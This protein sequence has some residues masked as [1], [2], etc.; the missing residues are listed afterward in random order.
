MQP[1]GSRCPVAL[2]VF[3]VIRQGGTAVVE[4]AQAA[5]E[6]DA[7]PQN[8]G[9]PGLQGG[10]EGQVICADSVRPAEGT[11]V[12][13]RRIESGIALGHSVIQIVIVEESSL[14]LIARVAFPPQAFLAAAFRCEFRLDDNH[15]GCTARSVDGGGAGVLEHLDALDI[16]RRQVEERID[17]GNPAQVGIVPERVE[18]GAGGIL[19]D[20]SVHDPK[21]L[22]VPAKGTGPPDIHTD[23]RERGGPG[24]AYADTGHFPFQQFRQG[25]GGRLFC[26]QR[27]G[28][29]LRRLCKCGCRCCKQGQQKYLVS[30][31]N[32][33][34]HTEA[35]NRS[36]LSYRN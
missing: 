21:G 31:H 5:H 4:T 20:G 9:G 12:G 27:V 36:I 6:T 29:N 33:I 24:A 15:A 11:P 10:T 3:L 34:S 19:N 23:G 16:L 25:R 32:F 2:A 18:V 8:L 35:P 22:V 1:G 13:Y 30:F 28:H 17:G 26:A 14:H 7:E